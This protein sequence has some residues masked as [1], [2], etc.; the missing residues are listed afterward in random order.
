[1][2]GETITKPYKDEVYDAQ[3]RTLGEVGEPFFKK[4][5]WHKKTL[6]WGWFI[7]P[8]QGISLPESRNPERKI[9][10]RKGN[11]QIGFSD[12]LDSY[13]PQ[14]RSNGYMQ[15][16]IH[17]I[18]N[19]ILPNGDRNALEVSEESSA[20]IDML[21][22][23]VFR[24]L[25][26]S[27]EKANELKNAIKA[28]AKHEEIR[29]CVEKAKSE[30]N[31]VLVETLHGDLVKAY[32]KAVVAQQKL[33][34]AGETPGKGEFVKGVIEVLTTEAKEKSAPLVKPDPIVVK[35]TTKKTLNPLKEVGQDRVGLIVKVLRDEGFEV[36][37]AL[38]LAKKIDEKLSSTEE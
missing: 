11:I 14:S 31:D 20:L 37:Q 27:A 7:L 1:M 10:L 25:W 2:N 5:E 23:H 24:D 3:G 16:E 13:F 32:G 6:A 28:I 21:R 9:R 36:M 22:M 26:N 4:F 18:S 35:P 29:T 12:F 33:K 15:G 30:G 17:L 19:G 38:E 8:T 34:K